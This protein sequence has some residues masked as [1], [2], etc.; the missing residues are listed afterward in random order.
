M[1]AI[2]VSGLTITR[3]ERQFGRRRSRHVQKIR[4]V[5]LLTEG[6]DFQLQCSPS[7]E[8]RAEGAKKRN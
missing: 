4:P 8:V 2:T 3:T 5:D 6:K 1:Q 7:P